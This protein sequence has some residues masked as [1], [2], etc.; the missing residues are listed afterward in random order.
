MLS[1]VVLVLGACAPAVS[2]A[3]RSDMQDMPGMSMQHEQHAM[4]PGPRAGQHATPKP[5]AS[6]EAHEDMDHSG[7]DMAGTGEATLPPNDHV[8]PPAPRH[9]MPAMTRAQM[10]SL[11]Q[12]DDAAATGM[13]LFDRMERARS[14]S[15][16]YAT[17]WEAEGWLGN[18]IDRLWL[19][20][21]GERGGDGTEG[22]AEALWS[23]AWTSFW[24]AQLGVRQDFGQGPNRQWAAVGVQGLAPYWF[25]TQ[26]T[27]YA[28]EQGRTAWRLEASYEL[29]FTQRLVLEPRLELNVYGKDDPRRGV[30]SGLSD[31]EAGLR[32]RYEFSRKFAPYVGVNWTRRY[33]DAQA[34]GAPRFHARETAW[35]AG[36]RWW[37]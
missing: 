26:A 29:L 4:P 36:L 33:G 8:P 13:L 10:S 2:L 30:S 34:P 27:F 3:Q 20:T 35:V 24:D 32:L 22:R 25:E 12:M 1:G 31:M 9:V 28:G 7:H 21:E 11:M 15:G 5:A 17:R 23:H 19:K 18:P 6:E 16:D 14:T 37:L